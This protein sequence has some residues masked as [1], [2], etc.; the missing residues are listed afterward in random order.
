MQ[1]N[2]CHE[3]SRSSKVV[4]LSGGRLLTTGF[5]NHSDRQFAIWKEDNLQQ[6]INRDTI[7]SS[8]GILFPYFDHD[9]Q[10][11]FLAG[12]VIFVLCYL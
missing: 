11:L 5:S 10:M 1:E 7:D 6:P 3:S 8:S 12:K 4:Y 9:T 2:V